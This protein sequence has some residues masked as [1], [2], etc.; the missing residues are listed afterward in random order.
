VS[1]FPIRYPISLPPRLY[2]RLKAAATGKDMS[3]AEWIRV[4]IRQRLEQE[5]AAVVAEDS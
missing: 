4:A 3:M 1:Q 5:E 2:D